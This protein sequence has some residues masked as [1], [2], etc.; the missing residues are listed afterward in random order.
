MAQAIDASHLA[1]SVK[2]P[3]GEK[4]A[5]LRDVDLQVD[6]GSSAAIIGRSG[7]GKTTLLTLLGLMGQADSGSLAIAG[8]D[9]TKLSDAKMARLRNRQVGFVFQS[10][11]LVESLTI[12]ENV[13]EPM[14]YGRPMRLREAERRAGEMLNLVG[15]HGMVNRKVSQL[16][17]GEQQR[18][19]IAR[20]LVRRP[21]IILADE[22]TGSL[23][24]ATGEAVM[25]VLCDAAADQGSCL[26]VVTHDQNVASRLDNTWELA[27][28]VLHRYSAPT[29]DDDGGYETR[30]FS[31]IP[32]DG[33]WARL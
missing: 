29:G 8:Q 15:L 17:G 21:Q 14:L 16:S 25:G 2:L 5:I 23:D 18:V 13:L 12:L 10:Y 22:P 33:G 11:S 3:D 7:S 20:A 1:Y 4:L 6:E 32:V 19:A 24:V 30:L 31:H 26:V 27:D 28:G 9:V